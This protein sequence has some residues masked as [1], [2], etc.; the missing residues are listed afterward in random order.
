MKKLLAMMLVTCM[1]LSVLAGCGAK[2]EEAAAET[3]E[4]VADEAVT[5]EAVTEETA[6]ADTADAIRL[7]DSPGCGSLPANI[8]KRLPDVSS[9]PAG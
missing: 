5:E 6:D 4:A 8:R 9:G 2:T 1:S 3:T 7:P